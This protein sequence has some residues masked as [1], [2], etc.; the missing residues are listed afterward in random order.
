MRFPRAAVCR[1]LKPYPVTFRLY[2]DRERYAKARAAL[3]P[4]DPAT[5]LDGN[6]GECAAYGGVV[7]IGV[8]DGGA[9]SLVHEIVHAV[10]YIADHVGLQSGFDASEPRAYLA[11]HIFD[12]C[13][14]H[15]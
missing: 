14:S 5:E 12:L 10:E 9:S 11:Q 8:F 7:V 4:D 1:Q 15:V 2:T 13:E 3:A 6:D